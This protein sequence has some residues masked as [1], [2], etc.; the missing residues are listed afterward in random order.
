MFTFNS[1]C[2]RVYEEMLGSR[3]QGAKSKKSAD[4]CAN[5]V[6]EKWI[7]EWRQDAMVKDLQS[8]HTLTKVKFNPALYF[9]NIFLVYNRYTK[10]SLINSKIP[11]AIAKWKRMSNTRGLW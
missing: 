10:V 9:C 2:A 6:F 8:K 5:P 1:Y 11:D 3:K 7:S 4:K